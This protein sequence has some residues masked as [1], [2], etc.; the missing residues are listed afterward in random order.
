M[1]GA[2]STCG[3]EERFIQGFGG[4]P[5]RKI[6]LGRPSSRW[7]DNIKLS[8]GYGMTGHGLDLSGSG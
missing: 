5:E 1:D 3:V 8:S 2:R 4:E 6:Q 7:R